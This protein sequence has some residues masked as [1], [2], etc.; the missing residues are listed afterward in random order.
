MT[1]LWRPAFPAMMEPVLQ[2]T[3][4]FGEQGTRTERNQ[5]E[6]SN[7]ICMVRP[8]RDQFSLRHLLLGMF[9]PSL[10]LAAARLLLPATGEYAPTMY[11]HLPVLLAAVVVSNLVI[12]VPCIWGSAAPRARLLP[13]TFAWVVFV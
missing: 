6:P 12:T 4:R 3:T 1:W 2:V 11:E 7:G 8:E 9:L 10:V 5:C 13:I